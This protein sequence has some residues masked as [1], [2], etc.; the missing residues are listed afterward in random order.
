MKQLKVDKLDV[1]IFETRRE[2]G[3]VAAQDIK[4]KF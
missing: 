2:M 1:K 3:E 4:N